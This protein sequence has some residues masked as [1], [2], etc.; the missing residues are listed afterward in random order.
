MVVVESI[1]ATDLSDS[2]V[3]LSNESA[4]MERGPSQNTN[5][6][7]QRRRYEGSERLTRKKAMRGEA[8]NTRRHIPD[9]SDSSCIVR[10]M[11]ITNMAGST[12]RVTLPTSPAKVNNSRE[13]LVSAQF[14]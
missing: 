14:E 3:T 12:I 10:D 8:E 7:N 13:C 4:A 6:P 2:G 9:C 11:N 1:A 5:A